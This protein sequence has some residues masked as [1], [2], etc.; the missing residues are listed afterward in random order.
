MSENE[1]AQHRRRLEDAELRHGPMHYRVK[2]YLVFKSAGEIARH[3]KLLDAVDAVLGPNILLWDSAYVI[4][5]P[6]EAGFVSWHQD[7]DLLGPGPGRNGH[8]VGGTEFKHA[9]ERMHAFY[10]RFS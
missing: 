8:G 6:N 9:R 4:K 5:E 1:A 2:P 7:P 3:S 10:S